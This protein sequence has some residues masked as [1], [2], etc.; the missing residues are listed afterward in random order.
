MPR[1]VKVSSPAPMSLSRE[2]GSFPWP[3][4]MSKPLT[5]STPIH[6]STTSMGSEGSESPS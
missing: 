2:K 4:R 5:G 1:S 3:T 6:A